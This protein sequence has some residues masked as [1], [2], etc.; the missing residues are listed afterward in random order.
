MPTPFVTSRLDPLGAPGDEETRAHLQK[1][2]L[3]YLRV[4]FLLVAVHYVFINA[5]RT[6]AGKPWSDWINPTA[7]ADL[8]TACVLLVAAA[9][10]TLRPFTRPVLQAIDLI[11]TLLFVAGITMLGVT[12]RDSW[13]PEMVILV[14]GMLALVARTTLVPSTA[15]YTLWVGVAASA[16]MVAGIWATV[17]DDVAPSHSPL[18]YALIAASWCALM[19]ATTTVAS[20]TI[21]GLRQKASL[22]ERLGQYVL[23]EEI[24]R[25]AMG[26]VY[27]ARHAMML[28]PT[29]VKLIRDEHVGSRPIERF[30]REIRATAKLSHPATIAVYDCGRSPDGVFFYAMELLDGIEIRTII[31]RYGP[32]H[33]GRIVHVM[34]EVAGSLAEAHEAGLI[35]RD[36]KPGNIMLCR[37]GGRVD[38]VK[39][40]DFGLVKEMNEDAASGAKL[41]ATGAVVGTPMYMS[42]EAVSTPSKVDARSDIYSLGATAYHMLTGRPP[43]DTRSRREAL[44]LQVS[45][46]PESPA[47]VMPFEPPEDLEALIMQC[48]SKDPEQRP[49]SARDLERRLARC[50]DAHTWTADEARSW[51]N[52]HGSTGGEAERAA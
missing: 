49:S 21:Y 3:L 1:R 38:V 9:I 40:L 2:L 30:K 32:M 14:G 41:S 31:R 8:F 39:V 11:A 29:A 19:V 22:A 7:T 27:R 47:S 26:V 12:A 43:F 35:H 18:Y 4:A 15:R 20:S 10:V 36:I 25:G 24:G 23:E 52:K 37:H 33:P 17:A 48:L 42:P 51:W 13:A 28:R 6:L 5:L 45:E 46:L 50:A 44:S 16:I 34:R